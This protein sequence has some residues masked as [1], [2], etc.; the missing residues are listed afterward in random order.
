[1]TEHKTEKR[2][3]LPFIKICGLTD[4]DTARACG[5]M[6][7][8]AVGLVFFEKSGR[9]VPDE[10]AAVISRALG[11]DTIAAGV[12]VNEGYDR[13]MKKVEKI[14]LQSVQLH[15]TESPEL[16]SKLRQQGV[17]VIKALFS[18][19]EPFLS[20]APDWTHASYLLAECGAGKLPGGN[21]EEWNWADAAGIKT[22]RPVIVAGGLNPENVRSA[23]LKSKAA[24]ADVSSGVEA[25]PGVKDLQK[26]KAFI[27]Q[28]N[29]LYTGD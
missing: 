3:G 16:V 28:M 11:P 6:G 26:V 25:S 15:G 1:M 21:A 17:I 13:I 22:Q 12:F 9:Y 23:M 14:P 18:R 8:D 10:R 19:K 29:M 5:E 24:G 7:A 4:P 20:S 2:A 27:K